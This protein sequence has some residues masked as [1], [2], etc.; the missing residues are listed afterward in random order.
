MQIWISLE[1]KLGT[2]AGFFDQ[3]YIGKLSQPQLG[4]TRLAGAQKIARAALKELVAMA[5]EARHKVSVMTSPQTPRL[6]IEAECEDRC[7]IS[8]PPDLT[9]G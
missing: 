8:Q 4:K 7:F 5:A 2:T 1:Q 3:A 9:R 6:L